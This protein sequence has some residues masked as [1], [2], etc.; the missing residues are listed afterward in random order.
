MEGL[1]ITIYLSNPWK[2]GH[3]GFINPT[4]EDR[5]KSWLWTASMNLIETRFDKKTYFP[6]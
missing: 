4:K 1:R 6:V 5:L 2:I 3:V